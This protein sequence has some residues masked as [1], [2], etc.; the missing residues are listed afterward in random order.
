M[1]VGKP[2][3]FDLSSVI[4]IYPGCSVIVPVRNMQQGNSLASVAVIVRTYVCHSAC[5]ACLSLI[6]AK[7]RFLF[8]SFFFSC[9]ER[10]SRLIK[11][12]PT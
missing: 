5:I 2:V 7:S 3:T 11:L 4:C 6:Q 12:V 1:A 10:Y 8:F 9:E